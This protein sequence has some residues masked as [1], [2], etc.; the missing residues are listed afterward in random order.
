VLYHAIYVDSDLNLQRRSKKERR[1][2]QER[3]E[4]KK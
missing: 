3:E 4:G 2:V 1:K